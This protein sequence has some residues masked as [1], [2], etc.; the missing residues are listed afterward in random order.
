MVF[1]V[2]IWDCF[3]WQWEILNVYRSKR[4][5]EKE[6]AKAGGKVVTRCLF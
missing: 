1:I 2:I 5:A 3:H 4:A 6:A